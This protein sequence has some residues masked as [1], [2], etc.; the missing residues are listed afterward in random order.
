MAETII[1]IVEKGTTDVWQ[2]P[3]T[4]KKI[5]FRSGGQNF[6]EYDIMDIG[7]IREPVGNGVR[8]VAWDDGIL[9]GALHKSMPWQ[10]G[11]W[12]DPAALQGMFSMW[13]YNRTVLTLI[14]SNSPICMDVHLS[15]YDITYQDGFGDYHYYIE[16]SDAASP[17]FSVTGIEPDVTDGVE[18]E[19]DPVPTTY[20]VVDGDTLWAIAERFLGDG[21]RYDEIYLL[22]QDVIE[23]AA[24]QEGYGN[25]RRG[26]WIFP[27]TIL[28]IPG[29]ATNTVSNTSAG[30]AIQLNNAPIYV[31][32]DA[33]SAAT[34]V[35]GTYYIYDGTE[36]LGRYRITD[37]SSD[38]GRSPIGEYVVG[39]LPKE[40]I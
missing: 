23:G 38:V 7:T 29:A 28:K 14:V 17:T 33:T 26:W 4:P 36:I 25:S 1:S 8:F 21:L 5:K 9:P 11:P 39:W 37:K 35:S 18:R 31:S 15:D 2:F 30:T 27:G 13:K 32:S 40:Y 19:A 22:N 20:T 16:F 34:R 3:W 24:Q 12:Q 6:V 10:H